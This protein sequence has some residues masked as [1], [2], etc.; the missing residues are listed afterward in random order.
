MR[1]GG[2]VVQCGTA[3]IA[4]WSGTPQGPRNEREVLTRRLIWG[5]FVIFDHLSAFPAVQQKLL[6]LISTGKLV[7]REEILHGLEAAPASL[8]KLY[9]GENTGKL[10]IQLS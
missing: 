1:V 8:R 9:A 2:R 3:S 4:D 5:G 10:L 7:H 6:S